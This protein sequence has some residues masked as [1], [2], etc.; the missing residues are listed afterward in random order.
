MSWLTI[1]SALAYK[2]FYP[3]PI[4]PF[5]SILLRN[6]V[7]AVRPLQIEEV[8][9]KSRTILTLVSAAS[10][11][12]VVGL[13]LSDTPA[14]AATAPRVLYPRDAQGKPL[15]AP[16]AVPQTSAERQAFLRSVQPLI[17]S[18]SLARGVARSLGMQRDNGK[19]IGTG[20]PSSGT[21]RLS[22]ETPVGTDYIGAEN[23]PSIAASPID[24]RIVVAVA[25]NDSSGNQECTVYISQDGGLT[26]VDSFDLPLLNG[27]DFCADPV[28]RATPDYTNGP[29]PLQVA[30]L[31]VFSY[32]SVR[33]SV[34]APPEDLASDALIYVTDGAFPNTQIDGPIV[35]ANTATFGLVDKGW[36][37]VHNFDYA[38]GNA[39]GYNF[40]YFVATAFTPT[41]P[42]T[43]DCSIIFSRNDSFGTTGPPGSGWTTPV[44]LAT[45]PGCA[46]PLNGPHV[47]AAPGQQVLVCYFD[48]G[49]DGLNID[50]VSG[51]KFNIKCF[52]SKD[53]GVTFSAPITAAKDVA[54][55]LPRQLGPGLAGS[56][57]ANNIYHTI[58][59]SMFPV[60][61]IDHVGNAHV[62]FAADPTTN[63]NDVESG[64][65][66]YIKSTYP[67]GSTGAA[68]AYD[69]WLAKS[70]IGTGARAQLFPT[71][72]SQQTI[73]QTKPIVYVAY[74]DHSRGDTTKPN[75]A[76]DIKYR[77][78]IVGGGAFAAPVLVTGQS[79][80]SAF[81]TIGDYFDSSA[82]SRRYHIIWTDRG[83]KID[84][85]DFESDVFTRWY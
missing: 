4:Q 11:V 32:L 71:V 74:A 76:Y 8:P 31:F 27:G 63:K 23:T 65:I 34:G 44:T 82:T 62:V 80:L 22:F 68:P 10:L 1:P 77:K 53:R 70:A 47:A 55:E 19:L 42:T 25:Q 38:D 58:W 59:T 85:N 16:Q 57:G 54:Y 28:V 50:A 83:D 67:N 60:V 41:S 20:S 3:W 84:V 48:S 78:S 7:E 36:I 49:V 12:A 15:P 75:I 79:S 2:R 51:G 45:S 26:Y 37:G 17:G 64:N 30:D 73:T 24:E 81:D 52:S 9:V 72:V 18:H 29:P 46:Q 66:Y 5:Q 33:A 14:R 56:G 39:D 69:K 21:V 40:V 35:V 6:P 13:L 61:D 43:F